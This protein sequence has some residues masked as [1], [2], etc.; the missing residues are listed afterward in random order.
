MRQ[1]AGGVTLG[2]AS[3]LARDDYPRAM[4]RFKILVLRSRPEAG[5]ALERPGRLRRAKAVLVAI[6]ASALAFGIIIATLL[7]GYLV[8]TLIIAF[9]LLVVL[10]AMV[11][12][13]LRSR[14]R[15]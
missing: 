8:A 4:T 11:K 13:V 6:A 10:F 2:V 5:P 15:P 12:N 9:V 1:A 14:W 7:L 3:Q